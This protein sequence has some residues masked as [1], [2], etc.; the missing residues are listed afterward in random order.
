MK[1]IL[2]VI[3]VMLMIGAPSTQSVWA[4]FYDSQGRPCTFGPSHDECLYE[5]LEKIPGT[6]NYI[7]YNA[8]YKV[9]H[10]D[11][12][13]GDVY[14]H[15]KSDNTSDSWVDGY[16]HGWYKGCVSWGKS[17]TW[18]THE[19]TVIFYRMFLLLKMAGSQ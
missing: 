14:H 5:H 11:G 10:T 17:Q 2:S 15:A 3:V 16:T 12:V 8:G 13:A 6:S 19:R 1:I 7:D 4:T 18:K 9:G